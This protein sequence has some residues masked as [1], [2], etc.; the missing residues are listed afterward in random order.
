MLMLFFWVLISSFLKFI[1]KSIDLNGK[2][3]NNEGASY[4]PR[5]NSKIHACINWSWN[6][7]QISSF[8]NAFDDPYV[9]AFTSIAGSNLKIHL[10]KSICIEGPNKFHPYQSGIIYRIEDNGY[11]ICAVDGSLFVKDIKIIND[12]N[13][14]SNFK[15]KIGDRL[16]SSL[17]DIEKSLK[18]KISYNSEGLIIKN[19]E[20]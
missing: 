9:G 2:K 1:S 13:I 17:K 18:T 5:L 11:Y 20:N 4:F 6:A 15:L 12:K 3:Q 8:I 19:N 7:K 14:L 16:Y 10:K